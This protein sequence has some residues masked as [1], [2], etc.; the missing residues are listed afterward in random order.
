MRVIITGGTGLIG[1]ALAQDLL[2]DGHE[3]VL[4]SRSPEK[5]DGK[6]PPGAQVLGWDG[7]TSQGW[8]EAADGAGAIVNLASENLSRSRWT[9]K[10]KEK[11]LESRLNPGRAVVE[12]VEKSVNMPGVVVQ[13]S[14]VGYYG[15]KY[16]DRQVTEKMPPGTDFLSNMCVEWE[17]S[18]APVEQ[19]GVRR[20]IAR[21]GVVFTPESIALRRMAMPYKLF[22][23]GPLGSGRQWLSW[24][25]LADQVA[26]LR[27]L[28]DNPNARGPYNL[29]APTP[30]TN[31]RF[32]KILG[33]VLNRPS[34]FPVPAFLIKTLFGE[35]GTVVL[36][37]QRAVPKRLQDHGFKFRYPEL[38]SA[39]KEIFRK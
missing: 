37:G 15:T 17:N 3:V 30:I 33:R 18:T 36:D 24:I 5:Q 10:Q 19:Y 14:A 22:V 12:A 6:I 4:L 32:G 21:I 16:A 28:I 39:L 25:H 13:A 20:A 27:F 35:M 31:S 23:G 26:A 34:W 1:R 29:S 2:S 38:E 9:D 7:R 11:L 8:A